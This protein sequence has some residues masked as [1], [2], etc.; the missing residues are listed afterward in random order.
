MVVTLHAAVICEEL[1]SPDNG[2]VYLTN[3]T[4]YGSVA[5]YNCSHGYDISGDSPRICS[6]NGQ[7]SG[8][9]TTLCKLEHAYR[10]HLHHCMAGHTLCVY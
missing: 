5:Y 2:L 8:N 7:W 1:K 10:G 3:E 6:T 4:L 9:D